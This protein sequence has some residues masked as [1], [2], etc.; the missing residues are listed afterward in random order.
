[1][2]EDTVGKRA[3]VIRSMREL[4][5]TYETLEVKNLV[6]GQHLK[7]EGDTIVTHSLKGDGVHSSLSTSYISGT[8]I[9]GVDD[10]A[11]TLVSIGIP[12][13][14]MTQLGDRLVIVGTWQGDTGGAITASLLLGPES[15]EVAIGSTTDIGGATFFFTETLLQYIDN[16]HAN[17]ISI[18]NGVPTATTAMNVAGFTWDQAQVLILTQDAA[19]N[20]HIILFSMTVD[21][22]PKGTLA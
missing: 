13:S 7:R 20:N 17:V 5:N 18:V 16:T 4:T 10:T 6:D 11:Q 21:V 15:S 12:A 1:M 19:L 9:A 3:A 14:T 8:G 2:S 22:L